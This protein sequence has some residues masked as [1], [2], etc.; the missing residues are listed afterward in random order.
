[1]RSNSSWKTFQF[2]LLRLRTLHI[3][4]LYISPIGYIP[5]ILRTKLTWEYPG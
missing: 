4:R 1:M 2:G 5:E 3:H